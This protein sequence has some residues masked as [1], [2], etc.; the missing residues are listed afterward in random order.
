MSCARLRGHHLVCLEFYKGQ[1]YDIAFVDNL[2]EAIERAE[3]Y[4][5]E[6]IFGPDDICKACPHLKGGQCMNSES[7]EEEI[8]KMDEFALGMLGIEEG[9]VVSRNEIS[10]K[11]PSYFKLWHDE[12]C[13]GCSWRQ[14]CETSERWTALT[15]SDK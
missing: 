1:G 8:Q 13:A 3:E 7:A 12:F 15:V 10:R 5:I 4:G 6:A 11:I 2:K 14:A 9:A